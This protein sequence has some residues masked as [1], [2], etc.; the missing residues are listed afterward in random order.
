MLKHVF[1]Q[2]L[3][4]PKEQYFSLS[5]RKDPRPG[6]IVVLKETSGF[7]IKNGNLKN[8][9]QDFSVHFLGCYV[10]SVVTREDILQCCLTDGSERALESS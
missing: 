1:S 8:P 7:N 2:H 5:Y 9:E 3:R 6:L 10:A 4:T